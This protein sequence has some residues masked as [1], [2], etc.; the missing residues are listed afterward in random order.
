MKKFLFK[1]AIVALPLLVG[2]CKTV[3]KAT[4]Q[5][6]QTVPV[7]P[8]EV[9]LL[10]QMNNVKREEYVVSKVKFTVE[11]G[12]QEI[13]LTGNMRMK[14]ND[15]IQLQLMAFGMVEAARVEL[16]RDYVLIMD[17]IN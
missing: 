8:Q 2:G 11:K 16:T 14:R 5:T 12:V 9:S 4:N 7:P 15:V 6:A 1:L 17:R 13:T 3:K 10:E